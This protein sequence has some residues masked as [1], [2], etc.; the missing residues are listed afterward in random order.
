MQNGIEIS[1]LQHKRATK[2]DVVQG[3]GVGAYR[4]LKQLRDA[5]PGGNFFDIEVEVD[6]FRLVPFTTR[7]HPLVALLVDRR[8]MAFVHHLAWYV[9]H[10][11]MVVAL[12]VHDVNAVIVVILGA[13]PSL[14]FIGTIGMKLKQAPP[15][16]AMFE[17]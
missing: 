3:P 17:L 14:L 11:T 16:G 8:A 10:L 7:L 15:A 12:P 2:P 1:Q 5:E 9:D 4:G 13:P 6:L